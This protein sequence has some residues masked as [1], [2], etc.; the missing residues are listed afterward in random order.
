MV[1]LCVSQL[2]RSL[3]NGT[4]GAQ[5]ITR[6][7]GYELRLGDGEL[8]ARRFER[9]ISD[10]RPRAALALWRGAPLADVAGEPFAAAEIRRLE[11][12][13]LIAIGQAIERDLAAGRHREIVG[14]LEALVAAEP[15]RERVRAQ[16]MLALYRCA[17]QSDA[18]DAY[19]RARRALVEAIGSSRGRSFASPR[20]A[21]P[22]RSGRRRH[23][24]S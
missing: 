11:E 4:E 5:I 14:E 22:G 2:R 8:D 9:L 13:R 18:L 6:G 21:C 20:S 12:L 7:H 1:R 24:P 16:L 10:G 19:R 23:S 17:R 3:P 15:L